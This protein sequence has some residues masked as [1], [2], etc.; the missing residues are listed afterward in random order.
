MGKKTTFMLLGLFLIGGIILNTW[1]L[2][3]RSIW[4][5]EAFSWR[6]V[7]LPYG[8]MMERLTHDVHPP[9][10]YLLL[11]VWGTVFGTSLHSIRSFSL[12]AAAGAAGILYLFIYEGFRSRRAAVV[13][14]G[15]LLL[16]G[17]YG[18]VAQEAR[19]YSLASLCAL[20]ASWCLLQAVHRSH[21]PLWWAGYTLA[22]ASLITTHYF[23][24][25]V[26]A[27]HVVWVVGYVGATTRGRIGEVLQSRTTWY[28]LASFVCIALLYAPWVPVLRTQVAQ[29][30]ASFWI[31]E[32]TR[33]SIPETI[34][35]MLRPTPAGIPRNTLGTKTLALL[36]I[37]LV[38]ATAVWL[39]TS[40]TTRRKH[41]V[42]AVWLTFLCGTAPIVLSALI[43]QFGRSIYQDR[44]LVVAFPFII[45]V[46]AVFIDRFWRHWREA[47]V[48]ALLLL[49]VAGNIFY[50]RQLAISSKP[51]LRGAMNSLM[52]LRASSEPVFV[53]SP[54]I[55]FGVD[56]YLSETFSNT[57]RPL[58]LSNT[59]AIIHFA[60]GAM[61]RS[62]DIK[63]ALFDD[64]AEKQFWL[65]ETTGFGGSEVIVPASWKRVNQLSYPEV[66]GY[67]G[68]IKV[69]Q[70][71]Q[72]QQPL[73]APGNT[74]D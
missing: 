22:G 56:H 1:N 44:Y 32:V 10:Y 14:A 26:L 49:S 29:V 23:G 33:W 50:Q 55:F 7:Q 15:L 71:A 19:M 4:F 36:P 37:T 12:M 62:E 68:D 35:H 61:I 34:Y 58:L 3:Q 51:G 47:A 43:S 46:I 64:G 41:Q 40:R 54:F 13:G 73:P 69:N 8:E 42:D 2:E 39:V 65:V 17:W 27:A 20:L 70:Y 31:P 28:A 6:A 11:K 16:S 60:G 59:P 21:Q 66:F 25:F 9:L 38:L 52:Q 5:D 24:L 67:Q 72:A 30:Q 53:T 63:T 18:S 74:P 57:T 45:I 48:S